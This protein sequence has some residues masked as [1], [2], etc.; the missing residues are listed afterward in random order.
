MYTEDNNTHTV[1]LY[2]KGSN[3]IP[4]QTPQNK[5]S[6]LNPQWRFTDLSGNVIDK[7]ALTNHTLTSFNGLTGGYLA[8]AQVYYKD[9]MPAPSGVTLWFVA[10]YSDYPVHVDNRNNSSQGAGWS[11]S[12][13]LTSMTFSICSLAPSGLKITRDG[14]NPMFAYY[15]MN[16]S[17]PHIVSVY[18]ASP[19][20]D[21]VILYDY[22][23]TNAIGVASG[24]V[25]RSIAN[26]PSNELTWAPDNSSSYL[27]AIDYQWFNVGGYIKS[28]VQSNIATNNVYISAYVNLSGVGILQGASNLFNIYDFNGYDIRRFNE[29]WDASNEIRSMV[30]QPHIADNTVLWDKYMKAVWGDVSTAQG[31][32]YGREAYERTAN[33]V[34]NHADVNTCNIEQLYN[35]AQYTDVPIDVYGV[36]LPPELRRIMDIASINQQILW[37]DRCKCNRNIT[38]AYTTYVSAGIVTPTNYKCKQC[39]HYHPG[40]RGNLFDPTSYMVSAFVPFIVEDRTN[41]T[42]KYQLITPPASCYYNAPE[43]I[44]GDTCS[45]SATSAVCLTS[46]PLSSYYHILLPEVYNFSLTANANDFEQAITY[47]CFYDYIPGGCREQIAGVINW[48]DPYTTLNE[49][50]STVEEWY[51]EG[52]TLERMINYVLHKGL[53]LIEE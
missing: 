13:V 18:G 38:N 27:S 48:D 24:P 39:G 19:S 2:S 36:E 44:I 42:N 14:I 31:E 4:W 34:A 5:W 30:R 41:D 46:Y 21:A 20:G 51:G 50:A 52:Q 7:L 53:G 9:D 3:S 15:W 22:P 47:F 23:S 32:S 10:D 40:N 8:S 29:S 49:S 6:H 1:Y 12:Q 35:L 17:I 11:N 26:I 33:F 43:N 37:G 25:I 28:S 16:A 45:V